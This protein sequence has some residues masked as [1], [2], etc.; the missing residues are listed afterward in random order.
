MRPPVTV[1]L[2]TSS[3]LRR[4]GF[5]HA[6]ST[7]QGGVSEPPFDTLD[8]SLFRAPA[9]LRENHRRLAEAVGYDP[10]VLYQAKQAHGRVLV[11]ARGAPDDVAAQEADVI[12][13]EAGS[14]RAAA[15]RVADCVPVLLANPLTG[16]VVAVHAGWRGVVSD[17]VGVG[18]RYLAGSGAAGASELL[19]AIG[20]CIGACCFEV[21]ADVGRKIVRASTEGVVRGND[22]A[23]DKV[24]IDLRHAVRVQLRQ[25]GLSDTLIEDVPGNTPQGCTQCEPKRFY[26]Y[27]RDGD[28]AGR[29]IGVIVA[30]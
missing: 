28:S 8:F 4:A 19:A 17:A 6:F 18:V 23:R 5:S 11:V 25:L 26:S 2:L 14:G 22:S 27:R 21:G 12:A 13:A 20:P 7:R 3:V 15:V 10:R 1:P 30:R 24:W 9:A 16:A 29:L